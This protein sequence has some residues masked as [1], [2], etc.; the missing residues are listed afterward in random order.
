MFSCFIGM[1]FI[2]FLKLLQE[3]FGSNVFFFAP[4]DHLRSFVGVISLARENG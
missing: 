3:L 1:L 2:P 4:L